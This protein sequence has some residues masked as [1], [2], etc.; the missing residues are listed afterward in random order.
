M[1]HN[2]TLIAGRIGHLIVDPEAHWRCINKEC[3]ETRPVEVTIDISPGALNYVKIP[4][5]EY[6]DCEGFCVKC[7]G[8][9]ACDGICDPCECK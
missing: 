6:G 1:K 9:G 5:T 2:W 3:S 4:D 8:H 7:S